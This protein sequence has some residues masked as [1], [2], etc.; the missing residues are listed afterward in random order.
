MRGRTRVP[1][2]FAPGMASSPEL[3]ANKPPVLEIEGSR[4]RT[5]KVG[6]PL[7]LVAKV[8]DDGI[9]KATTEEQARIR[10]RRV[11]GQATSDQR[12]GG[13]SASSAGETPGLDIWRVPPNHG[14]VNKNN[15]LHPSWW[16]HY[17]T[18]P[19]GQA[20]VGQREVSA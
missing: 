19:P 20:V 9:P 3:R 17:R 11:T 6:Q 4:T 10:A 18:L 2:G 1:E 16:F 7:A 8:T 14:S 5:V 12:S 15:G 13:Q